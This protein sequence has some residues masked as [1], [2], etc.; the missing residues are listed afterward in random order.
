MPQWNKA[1]FFVKNPVRLADDGRTVK[2]A[3]SYR[4]PYPRGITTLKLCLVF[5][6]IF[7]CALPSEGTTIGVIWSREQGV[8]IAADSKMTGITPE[9]NALSFT[10]CKIRQIDSVFF[11]SSGVRTG[12]S[13]NIDEIANRTLSGPGSTLKRVGQLHN[14]LQNE[15]P[16]VITSILHRG[17]NKK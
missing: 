17:L 8:I 3:I 15:L 6:L 1:R 4:S 7:L 2:Q 5:A 10:T 14:A 9:G 11:A 13:F 12:P 16:K